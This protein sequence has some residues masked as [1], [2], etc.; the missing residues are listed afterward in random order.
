MGGH[1]SLLV[2]P[3]Y[4]VTEEKPLW[5]HVERDWQIILSVLEAV[6]DVTVW[7]V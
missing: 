6:A 2:K 5:W 4:K 1:V 3:P 7:R